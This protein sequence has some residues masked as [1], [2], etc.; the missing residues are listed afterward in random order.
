[1]KKSVLFLGAALVLATV[2]PVLAHHSV[3]AYFDMKK[4][5]VLKG[6][7]DEWMFK[8]PHA[9]LKFVIKNDQGQ[10]E[11]WRAETLPSNLL[12]RKGWRFNTLKRGDPIT[13]YGHP[14]LD[15]SRHAMVLSKIV[16]GDGRELDP[17]K[18]VKAS[19]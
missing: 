2:T 12:F 4:D 14:S 9:V 8:A 1:M 3:I 16:L 19:E 11:L 10:A 17:M 18:D 7:V 13:V 6:E 15:A 5:L